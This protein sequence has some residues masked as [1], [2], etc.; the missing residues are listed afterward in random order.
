M[1]KYAIL[2]FTCLLLPVS[3]S[4][5]D[6]VPAPL[7]TI[8]NLSTV[9]SDSAVVEDTISSPQLGTLEDSINIVY[10]DVL[11]DTLNEAQRS[12]LEFETRYRLRWEDQQRAEI[13]AVEDPFSYFDSLATWLLSSRWNLRQ[14]LDRAF[15][16]DAGD[17]FR[18][19]P[20]FVVTDHQITPMRKTVQP[21]GL[22]GNRLAVLTNGRTLTPFEHIV[23]PDGMI[24]LN[25]IPTALDDQVVI[26]PGPMG[27]VFG[28]DHSVATLLTRPKRPK[29]T[30]PESTFLVDK[31]S[32]AYS[33]ARG[34]YSKLF[35]G[36]REIDMS[37]GYRSADGAFLGRG[38]DAYHQSADVFFPLGRTVAV[39]ASGWIYDREGPFLVRP[40]VG[41]ATH[42]RDRIDRQGSLAFVKHNAE[43]SVRNQI[44]YTH[45][46]QTSSVAWGY[47][48]R[49]EHTGHGLE[50]SREWMWGGS[51]FRAEV[52][53]DYL[54]FDDWTDAEERLTGG[55]SLSMA[56]RGDSYRLAVNARGRYVEDFKVL[57][58]ASALITCESD[59]LY[60]FASVGYSERAPSLYELN[61]RYQE[62]S[63]YGSGFNDYADEGNPGLKSERLLTAALGV[64][65]GSMNTSLALSA[66]GGRI[67]D[68][69]EWIR[70]MDSSI[71]V[72]SPVNNDV[73]FATATAVGRLA[74]T[75]LFAFKGGGSYHYVDYPDADNEAYSPEYQAFGGAEL[76]IFWSQKLIHFYAYG[77]VQYTGPYDGYEQMGLGD[78]LVLNGKLSFRMG[79]FRFHWIVQ[80][81]LTNQFS[82]REY[83]QS[84]GRY[85]YYGF[86]WDFLD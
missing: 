11:L 49:L 82:S 81:M 74:L 37:I 27:M 5:D 51:A 42:E 33:Y 17:Y 55:A 63:V 56:H 18:F 12:L 61:L 13:V 76:H 31:G 72:F 7:L 65:L 85:N 48:A 15:Y 3:A 16:H 80:N 36:G 47:R 75:D 22:K 59:R 6:S 28:G 73:D 8:D 67:I 39:Q 79:N 66:T 45:L 69:I 32:Y 77:E 19:D 60:L 64:E 14:D 41:G 35:T 58:A 38:D 23:E 70:Y 9:Q 54:E 46:R 4:A 57:P 10:P 29:T 25:D 1:S 50:L 53:G 24:D 34:R 21:Y 84:L 26:L 86:T 20:G 62:A 71:A 83:F 52:D 40:D 68:G 2:V 44:A 43:H 78:E 30:S